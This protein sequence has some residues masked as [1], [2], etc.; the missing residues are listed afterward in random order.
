MCGRVGFPCKEIPRDDPMKL[1]RCS[2]SCGRDMRVLG[3]LGVCLGELQAWRGVNPKEGPHAPQITELEEWGFL[4]WLEDRWCRYRVQ[5][6]ILSQ[7][8][9]R[10]ASALSCLTMPSFFL[11]GMECV[12]HWML[13]TQNLFYFIRAYS[14]RRNFW[15]VDFEKF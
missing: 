14:L 6:L 10:I 9:F 12:H 15:T 11:C 7:A 2:L 13:D 4:R 1:W 5:G 3:T 8:T